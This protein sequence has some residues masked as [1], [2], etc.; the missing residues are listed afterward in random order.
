MV[1]AEMPALDKSATEEYGL[2]AIIFFAKL[3]PMPGRC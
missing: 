1:L 2:P 3:G